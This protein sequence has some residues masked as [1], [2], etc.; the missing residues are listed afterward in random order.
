MNL[1][2]G[3]QPAKFQIP[4]LSE[5]NFT[6]V[7]KRHPQKTIMTSLSLHVTSRYLALLLII[8]YESIEI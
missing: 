1:D 2:I 4:E 5:S 3:Y 6:G 8:F 7:F